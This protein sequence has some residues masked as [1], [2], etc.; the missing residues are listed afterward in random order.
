M[1]PQFIL[2]ENVVILAQRGENDE[3]RLD[4]TCLDLIHQIIDICHTIIVDEA[5][6]NQYQ[7]QL[8]H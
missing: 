8:H 4:S 6:W 5:L 1:T 2:D 3:G 7:I